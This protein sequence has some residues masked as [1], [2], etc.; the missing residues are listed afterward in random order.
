MIDERTKMLIA[1]LKKLYHRDAKH[2]IQRILT[3]THEADIAAILEGFDL[4]Q[5]FDLFRMEPSLAKQSGILSHLKPELQKEI[6]SCLSQ[7][8]I[9]K[10]VGLMDT[11]D[12]ADLLGLL[13]EENAKAILSAMGKEDSDEVADLMG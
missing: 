8:Q 6:L 10:L 1:T 9:L 13:P 4:D 11:D 2:N 5:R 3:K 12:A 7:Q